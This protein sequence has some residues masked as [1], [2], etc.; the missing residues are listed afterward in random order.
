MYRPVNKFFRPNKPIA[1]INHQIKVPEVRVINA[2]GEHVGVMSVSDALKIAEEEGLD[3]VEVSPTA[4]PP[5]AKIINYDKYRYQVEKE[6][7]KKKK[8]AKRIEVKSIRLSV[9]IGQHDLETNA[10]QAD[11]FLQEGKKVKVELVLR[12]REKANVGFAFEQVNKYLQTIS[13]A[14]TIEQSPKKLGGTIFAILNP[15]QSRNT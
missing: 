4:K 6:E 14:H 15:Q 1:R 5:V 12:G 7:Q 11:K 13:A 3:L 9:R 8:Q 2:Q 10:S